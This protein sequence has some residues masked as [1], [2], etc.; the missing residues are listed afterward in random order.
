M[1][2]CTYIV[3]PQVSQKLNLAQS[4]LCVDK[5]YPEVLHALNGDSSPTQRVKRRSH[6]A[7][8]TVTYAL[9]PRV[10]AVHDERNAIHLVTQ[11][12]AGHGG[13]GAGVTRDSGL[14]NPFPALTSEDPA[15]DL[16]ETTA[17]TASACKL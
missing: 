1:V 17:I 9:K 11:V 4:A 2:S 8:G 12:G 16:H 5:V 6:Q 15:L 14:P 7:I 3:T 10:A 13:E